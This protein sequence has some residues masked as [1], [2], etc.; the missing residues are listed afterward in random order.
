MLKL[1]TTSQFTVPTERGI[2]QSIIRMTIDK[3]ELDNNNIIVS[4]YYYRIDENESIIVLSKINKLILR[5]QYEGI[6]TNL[7]E[8][9]SNESLFYNLNQRLN[10]ITFFMLQIEQTENFGTLATDWEIDTI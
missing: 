7:A 4:G 10:E 8:L 9:N 6:E 1:K 3:I 2:I 5:E